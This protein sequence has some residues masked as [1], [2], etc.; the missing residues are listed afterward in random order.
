M[1]ISSIGE[2]EQ[3]SAVPVGSSKSNSDIGGAVTRGNLRRQLSWDGSRDWSNRI[4]DTA[5]ASL[6]TLLPSSASFPGSRFWGRCARRS[7]APPVSAGSSI[8]SWTRFRPPNVHR[9]SLEARRARL[10]ISEIVGIFAGGDPS[11]KGSARELRFHPTEPQCEGRFPCTS[12]GTGRGGGRIPA[13]GGCPAARA[14][15]R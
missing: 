2:L 3:P 5:R 12:F 6:M 7:A 10:D 8:A 13:R 9:S 15:N 11:L 4:A 1:G 14:V